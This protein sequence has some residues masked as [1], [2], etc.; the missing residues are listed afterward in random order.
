VN[1]DAGGSLK[2]GTRTQERRAK[3]HGEL[4][5]IAAR[6]F[7]TNGYHG[8]SISDLVEATNIQR[9]GLYHYIGGKKDL[10][11][12]IHER[13]IEPLLG[14]TRTILSADDPADVKLRRLAHTLMRTID[15]Y[16][17]QVTVFLHEWRVLIDDPAWERIRAGRVE[18]EKAVGAILEEGR[19]DGLFAYNDT[20]LTV[21]AFL[22]MI[23]YSYHWFKHDGRVSSDA[24][25]DTF[26]DIFLRGVCRPPS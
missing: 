20:S 2:R 26:C 8:T 23:N 24:I 18:F 19:R 1:Q 25:A 5:D 21:L 17:D 11:I 6:V 16:R 9:G 4:V 13:F 22:G 3:R 15:V 12:S 7:A 14:D 10:L